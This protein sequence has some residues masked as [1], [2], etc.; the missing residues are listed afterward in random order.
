MT[1]DRR[2]QFTKILR[3]V[4]FEMPRAM[5]AYEGTLKAMARA[6]DAGL[7]AAANL[8]DK[9]MECF[10]NHADTCTCCGHTRPAPL[11]VGKDIRA[12]KEGNG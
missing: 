5:M 3:D 7:E 6:F 10:Y 2:Q 4:G 12:L 8:A 11:F 1:K 9:Q